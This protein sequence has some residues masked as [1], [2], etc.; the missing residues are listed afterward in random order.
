M[1][2]FHFIGLS[3]RSNFTR[4]MMFGAAAL[5]CIALVASPAESADDEPATDY[6]QRYIVRLP[7]ADLAGLPAHLRDAFDGESVD[8]DA[9]EPL[10]V[11]LLSAAEV[12]ELVGLGHTPDLTGTVADY[13]VRFA[14]RK[15]LRR[16]PGKLGAYAPLMARLD[17]SP[18]AGDAARSPD[19][20]AEPVTSLQP[21][22]E[23]HDLA[24]GVCF[25]NNLAD[26]YPAIT[27]LVSI[28]Q[29]VEGR[30]IW[31]LKVS[32][33]PGVIEP[34]EER[35][36][37]KGMTHA[38]EWI[39]YEMM[40]YLAEY[41]TTR[42]DTDPHVQHIV[43]N[44][45]VWLIPAVNPDGYEYAWTSDRMWRKNRRFIQFGT[46]G[47]DINR[48]YDYQWG[49]DDWGSSPN[50]SAQTYRGATPA[51]EPETQ[52]I[53][54]LL[55]EQQF[56]IAVSYHSYSQLYLHAWGYTGQVLPESYTSFRALG[57]KCADLIYGV[58]GE[59]YT[60][61]QSNYTIYGTNGDFDDYAYGAQGVLAF[62][63]EL[64]P[65]SSGE[66]GF[67]LPEDQI[68]PTV[69]EN[70]PAA[71]W[72]MLNVANATDFQ[73]PD[74]SPL[75]E[76]PAL[77]D[78][79]FSLPVTPT[80]QKP[81]GALGFPMESAARLQTW[82]DDEVHQP[83]AWGEFGPDFET[84][85]FEGVG[86][87]GGCRL[88]IDAEPLLDWATGLTSYRAL[89][90]VFEDG[91]S[92][93]LSNLSPGLNIIGVPARAPVRM[94]DIRVTQR[95]L[96]SSS[97]ELNY[98]E[99][100]LAERTALEDLAAPVPWIDWN[101]EYIDSA[102]VSHFSHPTGAGGAGE[103]V[104]PFRAYRVMVNVPSHR[105]G[106]HDEDYPIYA[107]AFPGFTAFEFPDCNYNSTPDADDIATGFSVDCNDNGVPDD[108]DLLAATSGDCNE[109][110]IPDEC[111]IAVGTSE[112]CS[113]DG[114]PDECDADCQPN[115]VPDSCDIFFGTS[116]DCSGNGVPDECEP[117][118]NE[119]GVA[120]SCDILA[121]TS[122]DCDLNG[123]PDECQPGLALALRIAASGSVSGAFWHALDTAGHVLRP[124][125]DD[126][127]TAA[128]LAKFHV[129]V[130][131]NTSV[132]DEGDEAQLI[133]DFVAAGGGL[134]MFAGA[135]DSYQGAAYPLTDRSGWMVRE[136]TT[137]VDAAD[138]L[139]FELGPDSMLSGYSTEPTLK[140]G[141]HTVIEWEDGV[142][143]AVT[144]AHGAGRVVYFNDLWAAYRYNWHGDEPYG[145]VLMRNALTYVMQPPAY[146]CNGN[147]IE[148]AC[149]LFA[150][151]SI[152]ADADGIP[153]EC[154][155]LGDV[156]C[157]QLLNT[158]DIDPFVKALV[159][160][161]AYALLYPECSAEY[162]DANGDGV[163]NAFDIDPFV[164][165]L[166]GG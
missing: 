101:W 26:A 4:G 107:L 93:T 117:D 122:Q 42:Y 75:I 33:N 61:G 52:A 13:L 139:V 144:F 76:A 111:D 161:E 11:L 97:Y 38:R 30:E 91:A 71:L 77:G 74:A 98:G 102:G 63:P 40:L 69:E 136:G 20:C 114:I 43:D 73:Q 145:T 35:I 116:D 135:N 41:L 110:A 160:P 163:L 7:L 10:A 141:A 92:V 143:L 150:G 124:F 146:D 64:R 59:I 81:A 88:T 57:K 29:S 15:T 60:P 3:M 28:G 48:N 152:D 78:N 83:P 84:A 86:T 49:Y 56:A 54:N 22:D 99:E 89:P 1:S 157:D 125:D 45:V 27:E 148:D 79:F 67:V 166:V 94:E 25:L 118:C 70:T 65:T 127:V 31:A 162:A 5:L 72:L 68:L 104:E 8:R 90:Y 108:C 2:V 151:T 106:S 149:D 121:G 109:N 164:Q 36:L 24:E 96:S 158:F 37:I 134:I 100:I 128:Y 138:P 153:D 39:T 119:S 21:Y 85:D 132:G 113:G 6:D 34:D 9:D 66:G 165:L 95:I 58:H 112:D 137:V 53:Q 47:V 105:F 115:G 142:P 32:D 55:A 103:Y 154:E 50:P 51:S 156:N 140:P 82:L 80:N 14:P 23:Y 46:Y 159:D 133:D 123:M 17:L 44:S 12:Q 19:P 16:K 129:L 18:A 62:T 130:L 147:G 155:I 131:A 87:G 126:L 120:D